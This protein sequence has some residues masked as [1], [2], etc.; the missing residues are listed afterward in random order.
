LERWHWAFPS[1]VTR[2]FKLTVAYDGTAL[3]GW[4][5]QKAGPS[6]QGLLEDAL[7]RIEGR[8]VRV[9]GAGRTDAGVHAIGQVASVQLETTLDAAT[10][11][12]ALNAQLPPEVRVTGA[13][14][15]PD[16]FH[17]RFS[18][19]GKTYR[20]LVLEA[21]SVSPFLWRY[22][23]RVPGPLDMAAMQ[24]AA[25]RFEGTRDFSA[26]QSA[27]SAVS[28][29]VRTVTSARVDAW[30]GAGDP[31]VP[32][33]GSPPGPGARLIT[34]EVTADGFLRHMVRAMAGTLVEIGLGRRAS[35]DIEGILDGR[36]RGAAGATAP[37]AGLWLVSVNYC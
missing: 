16:G 34:F 1:D 7:A 28:H 3:V 5:R 20:Y 18:A 29:A 32:V 8:V 10:L 33:V 30:N 37:A 27:G 11:R 9:A 17:A 31:P 15:A 24:D 4:Q 2:N 12:R 14:A 25:R 19:R 23:W 36:L 35:A 13:E 6:V 26:F 22:V 21:D